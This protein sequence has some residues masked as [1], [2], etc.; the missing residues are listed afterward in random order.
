MQSAQEGTGF[1]TPED[2]CGNKS[3]ACCTRKQ[4]ILQLMEKLT[5]SGCECG[6]SRSCL[7]Q[8]LFREMTLLLRSEREDAVAPADEPRPPCLTFDECCANQ[9]DRTGEE[10][11]GE[12]PMSKRQVRRVECFHQLDL[13]K[14]TT[15]LRRSGWAD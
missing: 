5:T 14:R 2:L 1:Q 4:R 7:I 8:Q 13:L 9:H 3:M 15:K 6:E 10:E 11:A 12:K